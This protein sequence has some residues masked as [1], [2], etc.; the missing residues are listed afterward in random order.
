MPKSIKIFINHLLVTIII[1]IIIYINTAYAVSCNVSVATL[2]FGDYKPFDNKDVKSNNSIY[3]SCN[4]YFYSIYAQIAL[5]A[6]L[7]GNYNTRTMQYN[8]YNLSYNLYTSK[9]N[10]VIW[11]DGSGGSSA[12]NVIIKRNK[13]KQSK[14]YGM[15][16]KNQSIPPG[17]YT[18]NIIITV[19]Y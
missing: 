11:G 15:I 19:S 18:D 10:S 1:N 4:N 2:S 14:I 17:I 12:V 16:P 13:T 5:S 9:N 6:G 8:N 7:S 3:I